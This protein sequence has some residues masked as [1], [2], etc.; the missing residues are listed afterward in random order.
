MKETSS[1]AEQTVY[2]GS[3]NCVS[4][5]IILECWIELDDKRNPSSSIINVPAES[6]HSVGLTVVTSSY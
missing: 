1:T 2:E 6:F 3:E 4:S 5:S